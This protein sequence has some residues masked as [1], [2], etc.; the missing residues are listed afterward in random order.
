MGDAARSSGSSADE[1]LGRILD[2]YFA[3]RAERPGIQEYAARYPDLEEEIKTLLPTLSA[4]G[5]SSGATELSG[6]LP[7]RIGE[8]RVIRELGRGGMGIV[9]EAEHIGL[10]RRVALKTLPLQAVLDPQFLERFQQ[11][12]RAAARLQHAHIVPVYGVGEADGL[13]FYTMQYIDGVGLDRVLEDARAARDSRSERDVEREASTL[14]LLVPDSSDRGAYLRAVARI[15]LQVAGALAH[16]HGQGVLHRDIK[17][18]NLLLDSDGDV[19]ITDFGLCKA[20]GSRSITRTGDLVGTLRYMAPERLHGE[21]DVRGDVYSL[22]ATLYELITLRP[23][24][25]GSNLVQL[26]REIEGREPLRP[27]RVVDDVPRD[28]EAIV[29]KAMQRHAPARYPTADALARDLEAFV[30]GRPVGAKS[31][32]P[33]HLFLLAIRRNKAISGTLLVAFLLLLGLTTI[34]MRHLLDARRDAEWQSYVAQLGAIDAALRSR[35]FTAASKRLDQAP[36]RFRGWEWHHFRAR[37]QQWSQSVSGKYNGSVDHDPLGRYLVAASAYEAV[38]LDLDGTPLRAYH[39]HEW[40]VNDVRFD[41]SGERVVTAS[42]DGT[43]MIWPVAGERPPL[44]LRG[45]SG[46]VLEAQFSP[47]GRS[48][49]TASKDFTVKLWNAATGECLDTL[50]GHAGEVRGLCFSS[51]GRLLASASSDRTVRVWEL[52][53]ATSVAVLTGH[54]GEVLS[55]DF[56]PDDTRLVSASRDETARV[57]EL[58]T[59]RELLCLSGHEA[60]VLCARFDDSGSVIAT[61]SGDRTIRL[62]DATRGTPL[63]TLLGHTGGVNG[64]SFAPDGSRLA[65]VSSDKTVKQWLPYAS[66]AV[67]VLRGSIGRVASVAIDPQGGRVFS[68]GEDGFVRVWDLATA[69][70]LQTIDAHGGSVA[71]VLFDADRGRLF[72]AASDS[73]I[74]VWD[75]RSGERLMTLQRAQGAFHDLSLSPDGSRLASSSS[76]GEVIIWNLSSG[77]PERVFALWDGRTLR[78][79]QYVDGGRSL[80]VLVGGEAIQ[81]LDLESSELTDLA[82]HEQR[83]KDITASPAGDRLASV[84]F[85]KT[86]KIWDVRTGRLLRTLTGHTDRVRSVAWSPDGTRL[87]TGSTGGLIKLWAMPEGEELVSLHGESWISDL[88]FSHCGRYLVSAHDRGTVTIWSLDDPSSNAALVRDQMLARRRMRPLVEELFEQLATEEAVLEAI[89]RRNLSA[90]EKRWARALCTTAKG[91]PGVFFEETWSLLSR[92]GLDAEVHAEAEWRVT[93]LQRG[94]ESDAAWCRIA[95][96]ARYRAGAFAEAIALLE[97]AITL[98]RASHGSA[99]LAGWI[100]LAMAHSK[101]EHGEESQRYLQLLE[102]RLVEHPQE[103]ERHG[104]LLEEMRRILDSAQRSG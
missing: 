4:L 13:H 85:D 47:D 99:S 35:D 53:G 43:A 89:A 7:T 48:V 68:C 64:L 103:G 30:E 24:F 71:K 66:G 81:I 46:E 17:P 87:A 18:S 20:E 19:W 84:A 34:Y 54:L 100:L 80:A 96:F 72:S 26:A 92:P 3:Y 78:K 79:V 88:V 97:R 2:E 82:G 23:A 95:G 102:S 9:Y 52:T 98:E 74:M 67:R 41:S 101:A 57:W 61:G 36:T 58:S 32:T 93:V 12:A 50:E 28:L 76:A 14:K 104:E 51:D 94:S 77:E 5:E 86:V 21:S 44:V 70:E 27:S 45:H 75:P 42:S 59:S 15:G 91:S 33:T 6:T 62:W 11:E 69:C 25:D 40:W 56:A 65:S 73:R 29:L 60:E 39:G 37:L 55:V 10:G 22:G 63:V 38:L 16:A 90:T 49:A 83:I 8:Y 1:R 31:P